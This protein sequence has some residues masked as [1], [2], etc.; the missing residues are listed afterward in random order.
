MNNTRVKYYEL[1]DILFGYNLSKIESLE[2][3]S[4]DDISINDAIEFFEI[5]K[6]FDK[7]IRSKD[8][9]DEQYC[10]YKDKINKLYGFSMCFI[11]CI[12]DETII[13]QHENVDDNYSSVFWSVFDNCKLYNSISSNVFD[14]LIHTSHISP[15]DL[16]SYKNTVDKYSDVLRRY[17]LDNDFTISIM[18]HFYEQNYEEGI[19]KLCIPK[20]LSGEDIVTY[21]DSYID[22]EHVNT[23]SLDV[24]IN[25]K[26]SKQFPISDELK[27]KAKR[28]YDQEIEI[29]FR[30]GVSIQQGFQLS[31]SKNQMSEKECNNLNNDFYVTYSV[32][33]LLETLDNASILNNFIYI[34]EFVDVPQMRCLHVSKKGQVGIF[35]SLLQSKS[36]LIY[37][38]NTAFRSKD[39]LAVMQ[40][41]AYY[42]FLKE[43]DIRLE[44]V[45][46]WFFTEYL[47][48][49]FGCSKM[50]LSFPSEGA[51]YAEKCSTIITV[52][53]SAVKQFI[54]YV[55]H[56]EID[57]ELLAMSSSS[58]KFDDIPSLI[59]NKYLYGYGNEFHSYI[60]WLFSDQCTFSYIN[61]IDEQKVNFNNLFELLKAEKVYLTDYRENDRTAFLKMK[62]ADI[63][64][65]SEEGLIT[66]G[67]PI[68]LCLLK[69]LNDNEVISKMH[70]P[71]ITQPVIDELIINGIVE[72]KDSLLSEPESHYFNYILNNS[73]YSNGLA[74]RNK[75]A[76]GI[77]QAI[78]DDN[79]H[80]QNYL[81]LL[82][83]FV[84]LAIKINDDFCLSEEQRDR[85]FH[86]QD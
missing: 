22:S 71:K 75:Y 3:P 59:E 70:Y 2:I 26:F 79:F 66:L 40:M 67:N 15:F 69:D 32:K 36:S 13:E 48:E 54:Q 19:K 45:L 29:M 30:T 12:N 18:L 20:E 39:V 72:A 4:I 5:K 24:T 64:R 84:I 58:V 61:H 8:W 78:D 25:M 74:I 11:K 34:F 52:F 57:F 50:R 41:N 27:L 16:F 43:N 68:I 53:E 47:E 46:Q 9:T 31:L 73:E 10:T 23:N 65:I 82:R 85:I 42:H 17:L 44:D 63:L 35:E 38:T 7:G 60:F 62:E 1:N 76:H 14:Q 6:Y 81:I 80:E 56:K 21:F 28:K 77:Q 86:E 55:K 37:P 83:L 33:W 51:T 49:E